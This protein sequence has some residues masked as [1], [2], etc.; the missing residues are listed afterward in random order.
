MTTAKNA[1]GK[2]AALKSLPQT[3]IGLKEISTTRM[4]LVARPICPVDDK[5]T[6]QRLLDG[7]VVEVSNPNYTGDANC[8]TET[9]SAPG[10]WN[11]CLARGHDPYYTKRTVIQRDPVFDDEG[12]VLRYREKPIE[13]K[14]LN[15]SRVMLSTRHG[16]LITWRRAVELKGRKTLTEMGYVEKCEFRNCELDVKYESKYGSF[17]SERHARLVGADVEGMTLHMTKQDQKRKQLRELG[18]VAFD[19]QVLLQLP[20]EMD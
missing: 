16:G 13:V 12:Y 7:Q 11:M 9:R 8:Q 2:F 1:E 6:I 18:D 3:Q 4:K 19:G 20:P 5:P 17:C 14:R 10:W 15:T